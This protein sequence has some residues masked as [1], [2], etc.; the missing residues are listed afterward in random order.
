MEAVLR[1]ASSLTETNVESI[2]NSLSTQW[3]LELEQATR[4]APTNDW[5]EFR[6]IQPGAWV[7][8][9]GSDSRWEEMEQEWVA[10][11]RSGVECLRAFYDRDRETPD[12]RE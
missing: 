3:R 11:Y 6:I 7:R 4:E 10:A 8:K 9:P 12:D 5:S 2:V 1:L